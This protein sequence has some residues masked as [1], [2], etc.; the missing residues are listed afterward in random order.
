MNL[1]ND[2]PTVE[3]E[4]KMDQQQQISKKN[5]IPTIS[6]PMVT[7]ITEANTCKGEDT[8][9]NCDSASLT[10]QSGMSY[11]SAFRSTGAVPKT[12]QPRLNKTKAKESFC[13]EQFQRIVAYHNQGSRV[14]VL[15]RGVPGSGKTYLAKKI[16]AATIGTSLVD[17]KT[18][19]CSTDDYFMSRGVYIYE[20]QRLS[21]AHDWNQRRVRS[22]LHQG[23]SPVIVD[24]TN[25]E[26]WEMEPY[27]RDGVS[28][29][30]LIEVMEPN[31][32]WAKKYNQLITRNSHNVPPNTIRKML[33]NFQ[34]GLTGEFLIKQYGL[35][36]PAD[37]VPPVTRT[38]PAYY[39]PHTEASVHDLDS[40]AANFPHQ[41]TV[42]SHQAIRQTK[43]IVDPSP[44]F[45]TDQTTVPEIIFARQI[46]DAAN[47]VV[48]DETNQERIN[49]EEA[50]QKTY[51]EIQK[52]L[53]E[54]EKV[55]QDWENGEVWDETKDTLRSSES[56]TQLNPKPPR[57]YHDSEGSTPRDHLLETAVRS[58]EDWRQ[59]SMYMPPWNNDSLS[60]ESKIPDVVVE[61]QST[62]TSVEIGDGDLQNTSK[63]FKIIAAIPRDINLFYISP[64]KE[65]IPDKRTLDK[66]TMT[67]D[68]MMEM[69]QNEEKHFKDFRKLFKNIPKAALRDIFDKCCGD[70]NWAVDI[71]LGGMAD[72]QL[73]IMNNDAT[74]MSDDE[75]EQCLSF[76]ASSNAPNVDDSAFA[77]NNLERTNLEVP[78]NC[79]I[80]PTKKMKVTPSESSAAAAA[81][82]KR[83]IEMNVVISDEHYSEH[84]QR[85]RKFRRGEFQV[86]NQVEQN[87]PHQTNMLSENASTIA[88]DAQNIHQNTSK[89]EVACYR[90]D[91]DVS[92]CSSGDELEKTVNINLGS[93]FILQ[94]DNLFGRTGM[95]YP[96]KVEP[97]INIPMS[98]LI[99]INAFWMESLMHQLDD[100]NE[101]DAKMIQEDEEFA[102]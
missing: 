31:T 97:K 81:E 102:R 12:V 93:E 79:V 72:N 84:L 77:I 14:L 21:E 11:A 35:S 19:I 69:N 1:T 59:I 9:V 63:I 52:Q 94:L 18:H 46:Q 64:N 101:Q 86:D 80:V 78:R 91:D 49:E 89:T 82:L 98:L 70:V 76:V 23:L 8:L 17:Y 96:E 24:N 32:P 53:A 33:N 41:Y 47:C 58:C 57:I 68:D 38:V 29:G 92:S 54:F 88:F 90:S 36:Y 85:I 20:R 99:E 73:Q 13:T 10:T 3:M 60:P 2:A 16:V 87:I 95:T 26:T 39:P 34:D 22:A 30:Y 61:R 56:A 27:L 44:T 5:P 25:V 55:E 66:S 75:E 43:C 74:E 48:A 37:M 7:E 15:M 6:N 100:H 28:N 4:N 67:N 65:K 51:L 62:G 45:R 40:T 71:V 83:Q 50:K 42:E